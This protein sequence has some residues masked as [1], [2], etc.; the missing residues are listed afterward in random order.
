M[1]LK[2]KLPQPWVVAGSLALLVHAA[3]SA[4]QYLTVTSS[5]DPDR[6]EPGVTTVNV[7]ATTPKLGPIVP[8][9]GRTA[10]LPT[11]QVDA[12][13]RKPGPEADA[14]ASSWYFFQ[15]PE[16]TVLEP[17][18]T[19]TFD[20]NFPV[21]SDTPPGKH[22][23]SVALLG[24]GNTCCLTWEVVFLDLVPPKLHL[25]SGPVAHGKTPPVI[26]P[27]P[28]RKPPKEEPRPDS[29][30]EA[31]GTVRS[32]PQSLERLRAALSAPPRAMRSGEKLTLQDGRV[33][34]MR[35]STL[36]LLDSKGEI[37][38][39]YPAGSVAFVNAGGEVNVR[40]GETNDPLGVERK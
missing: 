29:P 1:S 31:A 9:W 11:F 8:P 33:L 20:E 24:A 15:S 2:S 36:L 32:R 4:A 13:F 21:P 34:W 35:R 22:R 3:T 37:L 19:V 25:A 27:P 16:K 40:A 26:S 18:G 17:F 38:R 23:G 7:K 14:L 10:Y 12:W 30:G 6:V 28:I 39:S 5:P